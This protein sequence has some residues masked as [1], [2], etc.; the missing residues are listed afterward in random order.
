LAY[1]KFFRILFLASF[2]SSL[3]LNYSCSTKKNTFTRRAYHN[4]T[5]QYNGYFN[6]K[7]AI[8]DG[9]AE[10]AK[11][12]QDNYNR[13]LYPVNYGAK[14][15][16]S[17]ISPNMDRAIA[18]GTMVIERHSIFIKNE[19]HVN[20]IDDS[21]MLIGKANFYKHD[22][23]TALRTFDFIVK[24]YKNND[25]KY[26][27]MLWMA[28][29]YILTKEYGMAQS[30][31][32]NLQNAIDKKK[33]GGTLER[34]LAFTYAEYYIF[35]ENYPP[36]EEYLIKTT[37]FRHPKQIKARLR[38]ILGQISQ[39]RS[40][41]GRA[42][43]Y[44]QKVLNLSPS[45]ELAFNTRINMAK[46]YD[47][48]SGKGKD[49]TKSLQKM[50]KDEKN[51]EY[52]DQIYFALAEIAEKDGD[53]VKMISYL[54][55]AVR[56]S[57]KNKYQRGMAALKLA[58][59]YYRVPEYPVSQAYYDTTVQSLPSDYSD[60][61]SIKRRAAVLNDLVKNINIVDLEDSLQR[62]SKMPEK[63]RLAL[64]QQIIAKLAEKE[65]KKKA[66]EAQR[67]QDMSLVYRNKMGQTSGDNQGSGA[68][69]YFYN[70]STISYGF[71]EFEKKWNKR[72]LEDNWRLSNKEAVIDFEEVASEEADTLSGD[73]TVAK[74]STDP[75]DP[76]TYLQNL[77]LT[78][79][80][81][82]KSVKKLKDALY[83][84]GM[85]Y[86]QGLNDPDNA[87]ESYESMLKRFPDD[88][89]YYLKSC[90]SLY[91][92]F[93]ENKD[94]PKA[95]YYK[96]LILKRFPDSDYA[97]VIRDPEYKKQ[98][99]A[100]KNKASILYSET[101]KAF[102]NEE[103]NLVL[104]N[105][106]K[107]HSITEDKALLAKFDFL[108]AVSSSK[109]NKADSLE[110]SLKKWISRYPKS[111]LKPLVEQILARIGKVDTAMTTSAKSGEKSGPVS[112]DFATNPEAIH[113]FIIV[114]DITKVNVSALKLKI[115]DFNL[116]YNS[117]EKFSTS[118]IFLD[119]S[120][121]LITVSNFENQEKGMLYY[122]GITNNQY[123]FSNVDKTA[124]KSFVISVEN[125][126][127]L[128][129]SRDVEKYLEF[130]KANYQ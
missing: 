16:I 95:D 62:I 100:R 89:V 124:I 49:I 43:A 8:K 55:D 5:S 3:V 80:Q 65:A 45:Y 40:D 86:Y 77:P 35:Q 30:M 107:A 64:V 82:A 17:T 114:A 87:A 67:G 50:L 119:D 1:K 42:T 118:S 27:A 101:Y 15:N 96:N 73:S 70:P 104:N 32:D 109:T 34:D 58:N 59:Y 53:S 37:Q 6:G 51:K 92:L 90:Y 23:K 128:Y 63:Q 12:A 57:T 31:L 7:E 72:K 83:N 110:V 79:A 25:I 36:A 115:S 103:F 81:F 56:T 88:T 66:E 76:Q 84:L 75:K 60:L 93:T 47:G 122:T 18:K 52:Q 26:Q 121:Q 106:Q 11:V 54:K 117:L 71:T 9:E 69:W 123:V 41:F 46:C 125:Y 85:I 111:D 21:Y 48:R 68:N 38:F 13:V 120:H 24:R 99:T 10:L 102:E 108:H 20:W 116:K 91:E 112:K 127:I 78:E 33:A 22:Y 97:K 113:L 39:R 4:L 29:C 19:E 130:F 105:C 74:K 126:P 2:V 44:Y 98:L 14:E 94:V 61:A 28:K 129:K